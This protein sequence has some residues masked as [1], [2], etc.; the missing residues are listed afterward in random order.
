MVMRLYFI[1]FLAVVFLVAPSCFGFHE[2]EDFGENPGNLRM[3]MHIPDDL[4]GISPV[5]IAL[6]GCSQDAWELAEQS[7]WNKLADRYNFIV[8]YPEQKRSNNVSNCFNWFNK[9]DQSGDRGELASIRNMIQNVGM[10][11]EIDYDGIYIYGLS[12]GGAMANSLMANDPAFFEAGAIF[13]AGPHGSA[14]NAFQSMKVMMNPDDRSPEEWG[15]FVE[16][17]EAGKAPRVIV[18]HG[19][20]DNV[21]HLENAGELVDQWS[22]VHGVDT[23]VDDVSRNF[24]GNSTVHRYAYHN[25]EGREVIVYYELQGVRHKLAV[26]PGNGVNEG[27]QTGMFA[28]D[29]DFFSTYYVAKDFGL[30]FSE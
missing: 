22:D 16:K 21:V 8:L 6:H 27:G 5:V 18:V 15:R 1:C 30:I 17:N 13:A 7:G 28:V 24:E 23:Q 2:V 14:T 11:F 9:K 10:N 20:K 3:F 12:A 29:I 19:T 4:E 26:N 25:K